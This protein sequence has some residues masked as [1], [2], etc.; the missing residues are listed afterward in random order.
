MLE[1]L[2]LT[3]QYRSTMA[4]FIKGSLMLS[5]CFESAELANLSCHLESEDQKLLN[6]SVNLNL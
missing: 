6:C 4:S 5:Y 2:P 3:N 1:G